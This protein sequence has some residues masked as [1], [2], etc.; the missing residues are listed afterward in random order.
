MLTRIEQIRFA[1]YGALGWVWLCHNTVILTAYLTRVN[2]QSR[3][4]DVN[5][6]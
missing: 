4:I 6:T 1:V 3:A 2:V 5:A